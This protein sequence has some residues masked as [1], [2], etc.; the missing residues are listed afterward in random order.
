MPELPDVERFRRVLEHA[1]G[2]RIGDVEVRDPGVLRQLSARRLDRAL[3]GHCLGTPRRHGK[4]LI[5]P[6]REP[7][8][9]HRRDEPSLAFHFGMTGELV[10]SGEDSAPPH[11]HDRVVIATAGGELRYRDMRKLQGLRMAATDAHIDELLDA[12]GPDAATIS[13]AELGRR[14]QRTRRQLKPALMDQGVVAGLGNLLVDEILW[15]ARVHPT[16]STSDLSGS[17]VH[18][19]HQRMRTV[20]RHSMREGRVLTRASWLTGRRD[21]QDGRC[22]RCGTRLRHITVGGRRSVWCPRCQP[23]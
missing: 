15:R 16:H 19:I 20:L 2:R 3:V 22:P 1:A 8:A 21:E 9:R 12:S 14:L 4:W 18:R 10:W 13:S 23:S 5:A 11:R 6:V 17:D 7:Q